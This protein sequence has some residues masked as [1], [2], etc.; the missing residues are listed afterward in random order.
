MSLVLTKVPVMLL[1][2]C[3]D[4]ICDKNNLEEIRFTLAHSSEGLQASCDR[5]GM[6]AGLHSVVARA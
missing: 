3:C 5:E 1:L 6:V 2:H 4:H